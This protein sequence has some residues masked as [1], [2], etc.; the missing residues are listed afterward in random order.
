MNT[1]FLDIDGVLNSLEYFMNPPEDSFNSYPL[2]EFDKR[3]INIINKIIVEC[4]ISTL[5]I[6][7]DWRNVWTKEELINIFISVGLKIPSKV[8]TTECF[9]NK[10]SVDEYDKI[11]RGHEIQKY[12][13]D[14]NIINYIIIDDD[15]RFLEEQQSK[16]IL[17]SFNNG[18]QLN[19]V[20]KAKKILNYEDKI[21]S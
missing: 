1:L 4:N 6:S 14:N 3:A 5:V 11:G 12:I 21:Q 15:N 7:S 18:I 17:T 9:I 2:S 10:F 20:I 16:L 19:H 13:N 8:D